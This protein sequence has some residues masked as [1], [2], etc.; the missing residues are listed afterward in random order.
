MSPNKRNINYLDPEQDKS[1]TY[2][3]RIIFRPCRPGLL[4]RRRRRRG[5][6]SFQIAIS[7]IHNPTADLHNWLIALLSIFVRVR[8]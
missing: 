6:S 8:L 1:S 5:A 7:L 4:Q 2:Q 3:L